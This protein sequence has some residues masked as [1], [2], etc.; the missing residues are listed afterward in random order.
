MDWN[1]LLERLGRG[2]GIHTEFKLKI[3]HPD[4]LAAAI[5]SMANTDGGEIIIGVN[6]LRQSVGVD[7][8]ELDAIMKQVDNVAR[9]NC[10][11]PLTVVQETIP[12]PHGKDKLC[13]IIHVPKGQQRPYRTNRGVYYIRTTS[14]RQQASREE[15]LRLFQS[16]EALHIDE[17]PCRGTSTADLDVPYFLKFFQHA[18]GLTIEESGL[19]LEQVLRNMRLL[20]KDNN[21]TLAGMALFG[22][23]P[24]HF[25]PHMAVYSARMEGKDMSGDILDRK[26]IEGNLESQLLGAEAFI[27]LHL[28]ERHRI[29]GFEPERQ[30]ELPPE[31]FREAIIN[32]LV[33]RDYTVRAPLRL[34]IFDDRVEVHTPGKPPNTVDVEAMKAGIHVPRNPIIL[35]HMAKM[36]YVT[37]IGSGVPRIF[38]LVT[39]TVGR[40]PILELTSAELILTVP[41]PDPYL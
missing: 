11:P 15:L 34:L 21:L 40:P 22:R 25:Y 26:D 7:L 2:E 37:R 41:R 30:L 31:I 10:E 8:N 39:E 5:V 13:V 9:N 12:I 36:G 1:D 29:R 19:S 33:H 24:Q 14:G 38:R 17:L 32:A 3:P 23:Q 16:A 28:R 35:T 6:D 27:R 4:D 20:T 18:Y